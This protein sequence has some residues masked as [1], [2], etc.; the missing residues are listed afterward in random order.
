MALDNIELLG[1]SPFLLR[2]EGGSK[3]LDVRVAGSE[4]PVTSSSGVDPW[5]DYVRVFPGGEMYVVCLVLAR[6]S[7]CH[8]K[9]SSGMSPNLGRVL[10]PA[11]RTKRNLSGLVV[12]ITGFRHWWVDLKGNVGEQGLE[13]LPARQFM[14]HK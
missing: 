2:L 8:A 9:R 13:K 7:R 14:L 4:A 1:G 3:G 6:R 11:G 10:F 12:C 5:F